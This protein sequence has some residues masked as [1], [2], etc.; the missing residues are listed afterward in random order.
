MTTS[1]KVKQSIGQVVLAERDALRAR[2]TVLERER[3]TAE[4]LLARKDV[5]DAKAA[6]IGAETTTRLVNR[7]AELEA[8]V[9]EASHYVKEP[10]EVNYA[11]IRAAL[12]P[13]SGRDA[14]AVVV[15]EHI[16][17]VTARVTT[18]EARVAQLEAQLDA[19]A[20]ALGISNRTDKT[21]LITPINRL[22]ARVGALRDRVNANFKRINN[23][24]ALCLK[25]RNRSRSPEVAREID[26]VLDSRDP[27]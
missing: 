3:D 22:R 4:G 5:L 9:Q 7:V 17:R 8:Q 11:T 15:T 25:F 14:Y 16:E 18:A 24:E 2:V 19:V 21:D 27:E 23:L 13:L 12:A 20:S 6:Q 1:S 26:K 10:H